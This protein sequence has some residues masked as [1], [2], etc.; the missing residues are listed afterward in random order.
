VVVVEEGGEGV[1]NA[2][3]ALPVVSGFEFRV[4]GMHGLGA[5]PVQGPS[6]FANGFRPASADRKSKGNRMWRTRWVA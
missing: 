2:A 5:A 4:S 3:S 1:G 6:A